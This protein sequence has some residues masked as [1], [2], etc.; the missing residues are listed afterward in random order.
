MQKVCLVIIKSINFDHANAF[1]HALSEL[2]VEAEIVRMPYFPLGQLTPE[3]IEANKECSERK[4]C[5]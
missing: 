5:R 4:I 1:Q 2:K 3:T